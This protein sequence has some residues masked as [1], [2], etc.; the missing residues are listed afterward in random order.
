MARKSKVQPVAAPRPT[1]RPQQSSVSAEEFLGAAAVEPP[2]LRL[3]DPLEE[4]LT[5][6]DGRAFELFALYDYLQQAGAVN[7]PIVPIALSGRRRLRDALQQVF[8]WLEDNR[9]AFQQ[10]NIK[11][12]RAPG[13]DALIVPRLNQ[14]MRDAGIKQALID[15]TWALYYAGLPRNPM[16]GPQAPRQRRSRAARA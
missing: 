8:F 10:L 7:D 6:L 16:L 1:P 9:L 3:P 2:G 14:C 5:A 12:G 15:K 11:R 13:K 4:L